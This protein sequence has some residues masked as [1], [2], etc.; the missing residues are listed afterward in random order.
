MTASSG[1]PL[2]EKFNFSRTEDWPKW[3]RRF[4][5]YRQASELNKKDDTLQINTLIYAMGHQAEDILTSLKLTQDE[6]KKYGTVKAKLDS[7]FV[8]R[9]NVIFERSKF[10]K[11]VQLE[12]ETVDSFVTDLHCMAEHCQ[13]GDINDELI[14][15]R[16]VVGLRDTRLAERLQLDPELTLEKA[17]NQARQSEAL[18]KQQVL[19]EMIRAVMEIKRLLMQFINLNFIE[20]KNNRKGKTRGIQLHQIQQARGVE[21]HPHML[22]IHALPKMLYAV[23]VQRKDTL[24]KYVRVK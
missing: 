8:I 7:Y 20:R 9:R 21:S 10:N 16:L 22:E 12:N 14:R 5:R 1:I 18:E 2:P 17:V 11:R 15:D 3:I 4:E 13:F 19:L 24:L 23:S 6:L